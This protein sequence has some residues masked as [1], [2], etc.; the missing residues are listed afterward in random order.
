M[1]VLGL[2]HGARRIGIALGDTESRIASPWGVIT[3]DD[4]LDMLARI[5]DIAVRDL[6]ET[7]VV[8][9]PHLTRR[10]GQETEQMNEARAF[11]EDVKRWG[12]PV[13]EEDETLTSKLAAGQVREMGGKGKRDDLAAV[14]ILQSWLDRNA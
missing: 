4:R 13:H 10:R 9:V 5:H 7:I 11:V 12:L 2:D 8:G 1:R 6:V 3:Y 14:A